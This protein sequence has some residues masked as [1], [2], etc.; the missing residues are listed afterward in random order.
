MLILRTSSRA[1]WGISLWYLVHADRSWALPAV[2]LFL[3][4]ILL[5]YTA[6][7]VPVQ[8]FVWSYDNPCNKFPTLYLDNFVDAFFIVSTFAVRSIRKALSAGTALSFPITKALKE[9]RR[10][11]STL[12]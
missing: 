1:L 3:T 9:H 12:L 5:L 7:V 10:R 2:T 6:V 11:K 4:G 8:I